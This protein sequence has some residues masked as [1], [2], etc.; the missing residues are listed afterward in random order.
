LI[1]NYFR[2]DLHDFAA[3]LMAEGAFRK[4]AVLVFVQVRTADPAVFHPDLDLAGSGPGLLDFFHPD[5]PKAVVNG[6]FHGDLPSWKKKIQRC[7]SSEE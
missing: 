3:G 5:I 6:R 4:K 1:T 7:P 2:A